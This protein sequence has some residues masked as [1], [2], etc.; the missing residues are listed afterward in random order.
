M[1]KLILGITA[2][3]LLAVPATASAG[4]PGAGKQWQE[5]TGCTYGDIVRMVKDTPGHPSINGL[6]AKNGLEAALAAVS[7]GHPVPAC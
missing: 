6:G 1:K 5:I 4:A 7:G 3:A 2:A